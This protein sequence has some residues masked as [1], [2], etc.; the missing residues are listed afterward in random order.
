MVSVQLQ[1]LAM[2]DRVT[3]EAEAP[4]TSSYTIKFIPGSTLETLGIP[5]GTATNG[6]SQNQRS[7]QAD[8]V[9]LFR[10]KRYIKRSKM[11]TVPIKIFFCSF[12]F[13]FEE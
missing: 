5:S 9:A 3:K 4:Q 12:C 13:N 11:V 1:L 7:G 6:V 8:S 10:F 2:L